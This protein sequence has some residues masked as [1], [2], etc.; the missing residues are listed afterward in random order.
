MRKKYKDV[1]FMP[2]TLRLIEKI[3]DIVKDYQRQCPDWRSA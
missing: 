1:R 3:D 2:R